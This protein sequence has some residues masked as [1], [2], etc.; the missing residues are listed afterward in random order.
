MEG[1]HGSWGTVCYG[2]DREG[3]AGTRQERR[4]PCEHRKTIS[5]QPQSGA[6]AHAPHRVTTEAWR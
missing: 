1:G 5:K 4:P 6:V 3:V 2:R